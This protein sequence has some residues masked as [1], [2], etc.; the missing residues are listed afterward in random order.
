M[1]QKLIYLCFSLLFIL[2]F[3]LTACSGSNRETY[4]IKKAGIYG[5]EDN[6]EVV[7][8]NVTVRTGDVTLRNMVINENLYL[9][10]HAQKGYINFQNITVNGTMVISGT[11][12]Q[13]S[14]DGCNVNN[15]VINTAGGSTLLTAPGS[16]I[17]NARI[18]SKTNFFAPAENK[19]SFAN[20]IIDTKNVVALSG[21]KCGSLQVACKDAQVYI[22]DGDINRFEVSNKA[23]N[24]TVD[25]DANTS[26]AMLLVDS[27]AVFTGKGV[28]SEAAINAESVLA[29]TP[30]DVVIMEGV[31]VLIDNK[32]YN[33]PEEN[34]DENVITRPETP[35]DF[36]AVNNKNNGSVVLSWKAADEETIRFTLFKND[37]Y[38]VTTSRTSFED[39]NI[40]SDTTYS[41]S[42]VAVNKAGYYSW[43]A[44]FT[45][46]LKE[47]KLPP[48]SAEPDPNENQ[49]VE[50]EEENGAG[51]N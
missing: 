12:Q 16:Q 17:A 25:L 40:K 51:N 11:L 1:K 28:I 39:V 26:I 13:I 31:Y 42:L 4:L 2:L 7:K 18:E 19:A 38:V 10:S 46:T 49:E 35:L 27:N 50:E 5:S 37:V 30:G 21:S 33:K 43:P 6:I 32:S 3:I 48:P 41:Y 20:I 24:T 14:L 34:K 29:M 22:K 44:R 15:L 23:V 36:T 47:N 9:S 45:I 8:D